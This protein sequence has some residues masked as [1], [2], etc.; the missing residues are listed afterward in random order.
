MGALFFW[1]RWQR[2]RAPTASYVPTVL[3]R[4][5]RGQGSLIGKGACK[6]KALLA[7]LRWPAGARD[8]RQA[9]GPRGNECRRPPPGQCRG[10]EKRRFEKRGELGRFALKKGGH[11]VVFLC[12]KCGQEVV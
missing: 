9:R 11:K 6:N 8:A 3:Q 5:E 10:G 2:R 7:M 1:A 4:G 12:A